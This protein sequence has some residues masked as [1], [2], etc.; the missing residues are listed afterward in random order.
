MGA[1]RLAVSPSLPSPPQRSASRVSAEQGSWGCSLAASG[2][3]SNDAFLMDIE[4]NIVEFLH[5]ILLWCAL[6]VGPKA[7]LDIVSPGGFLFPPPIH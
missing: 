6:R 4:S 2:V 5:G 3:H 7:A 1:Q